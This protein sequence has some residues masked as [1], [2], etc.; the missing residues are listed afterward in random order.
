VPRSDSTPPPTPEETRRHWV[1]L[2]R[3]ATTLMAGTLVY[4]GVAVAFGS[5]ATMGTALVG[6]CGS[7]SAMLVVWQLE[8]RRAARHHRGTEAPD[9]PGTT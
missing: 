3:G 1:P 7:L 2:L 5:N 6:M 8:A 4:C 9:A